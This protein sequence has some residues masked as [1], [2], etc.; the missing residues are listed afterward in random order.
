M[1]QIIISRRSTSYKEVFPLR[2]ICIA[3]LAL[4]FDDLKKFFYGSAENLY[5]K[6]LEASPSECYF[7][8]I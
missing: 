7:A 4:D 2:L 6:K 1:F 5:H 8:L 3:I